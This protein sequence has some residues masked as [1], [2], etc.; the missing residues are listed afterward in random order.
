MRRRPRVIQ[1]MNCL[2]KVE[3]ENILNIFCCPF[4]QIK[5]FLM[6]FISL[7]ENPRELH[8]AM[9]ISL[10]VLMEDLIAITSLFTLEFF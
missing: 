9:Q 3:L 4:P 8:V 1:F 5:D 7:I 6:F 10:V 2:G